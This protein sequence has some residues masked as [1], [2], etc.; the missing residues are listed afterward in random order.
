MKIRDCV[1]SQ[2][3]MDKF[4]TYE[5]ALKDNLHVVRVNNKDMCKSQ[6]EIRSMMSSNQRNSKVWSSSSL[7]R[8]HR[9]VS[10]FNMRE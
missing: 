3:S 5:D 1:I 6:E 9:V 2:R 10:A 7:L 8:V 4:L